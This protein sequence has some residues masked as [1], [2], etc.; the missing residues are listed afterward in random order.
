MTLPCSVVV[1]LGF[2]KSEY[3]E[4]WKLAMGQQDGLL[5][6]YEWKDMNVRIVMEMSTYYVI[7]NVL[8]IFLN[9]LLT[10]LNT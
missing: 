7:E 4:T 9:A 1:W 2:R 10:L 6:S 3:D 5:P 8:R